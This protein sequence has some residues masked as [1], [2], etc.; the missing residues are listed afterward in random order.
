MLMS[1]IRGIDRA[2]ETHLVRCNSVELVRITPSTKV[3]D[4]KSIL[5]TSIH[6]VVRIIWVSQLLDVLVSKQTPVCC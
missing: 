3:S 1:L 4:T 5:T 6:V 2:I